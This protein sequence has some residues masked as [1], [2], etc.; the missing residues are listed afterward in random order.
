MISF[1]AICAATRAEVVLMQ[2]S[3]NFLTCRSKPVF[4]QRF[5]T[6]NPLI[7]IVGANTCVG[8]A[9][10]GGRRRSGKGK[11]ETEKRVSSCVDLLLAGLDRSWFRSAWRLK[12]RTH[13]S[14]LRG[15][16]AVVR[17]GRLGPVPERG[18]SSCVQLGG[19]RDARSVKGVW[20]ECRT[21]Q[22]PPCRWGAFP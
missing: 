11:T 4:P 5:A 22:H 12:K 20:H 1:L 10:T 14:R 21:Q 18:V 9:H 7:P 3:K 17:S 13:Y 6:S 16:S 8:G 19:G 2:G 15:C